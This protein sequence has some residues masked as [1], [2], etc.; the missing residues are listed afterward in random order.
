MIPSNT[1]RHLVSRPGLGRLTAALAAV[2][3][4][5]APSLASAPPAS[6]QGT[7]A[8]V[9][10]ACPATAEPGGG[11]ITCTIRVQNTSSVPILGALEIN[12]PVVVNYDFFDTE[13]I[14]DSVTLVAPFTAAG[15]VPGS[16]VTSSNLPKNYDGTLSVTVHFPADAHYVG[17]DPPGFQATMY[18]TEDNVLQKSPLAGD[19]TDFQ[20]APVADLTLYLDN[21]FRNAAPGATILYE[22][23]VCNDGPSDVRGV[24]I[25]FTAG[26]NLDPA[27]VDLSPNDDDIYVPAG[28]CRSVLITV[29][30]RDDA[31]IGGTVEAEAEVDASSVDWGVAPSGTV[32]EPS[33]DSDVPNFVIY[34]LPDADVEVESLQLQGAGPWVPG[35]SRD[36]SRFG[37]ATMARR[38]PMAPLWCWTRWTSWP[39]RTIP[40][41]RT[42]T[43]SSSAGRA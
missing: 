22:A 27:T 32:N 24:D 28:Q 3:I 12:G 23:K 42:R 34:A 11:T 5:W 19:D 25:D 16:F 10:A 13:Y 33:N 38:W 39:S 43:G 8:I 21:L 31:P 2:A 26:L 20:W 41:R 6:A 9:T 17:N 7:S 37:C 36:A 18:G 4:L 15:H 40:V 29:R 35:T 30:V 1:V 14:V